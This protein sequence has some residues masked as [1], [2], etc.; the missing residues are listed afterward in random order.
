VVRFERIEVDTNFIKDSVVLL[1]MEDRD[2][3]QTSFPTAV[4]F[5]R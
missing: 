4:G 5:T 2:V 1:G 3:T